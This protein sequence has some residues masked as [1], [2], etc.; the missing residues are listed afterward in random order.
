[1]EARKVYERIVREFG[2][3]TQAVA[4]ARVQL[5][6]AGASG[7]EAATRRVWTATPGADLGYA[8]ASA[9]G[10]FVT[11]I[12]YS[13]HNLYIHDL[14]TGM[15]RQLTDSGEPGKGSDFPEENAFSRDG[16]QLAYAWYKAK[17]L[18][19]EVRV[20]DLTGSG[21]PRF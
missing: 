2:D 3:Q 16:K 19:W 15:T 7:K 18:R 8:N 14:A 9:D 11:Y 4:A 6:V 12:D 5:G 10:R 13:V 21:I 1:A 17:D 20:V